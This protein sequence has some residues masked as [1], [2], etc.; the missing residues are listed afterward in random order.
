M[1]IVRLAVLIMFLSSACVYADDGN[2]LASSQCDSSEI[3]IQKVINKHENRE[4]IRLNGANI[5]HSM[6]NE[7]E[8][9]YE[10]SSSIGLQGCLNGTL[11]RETHFFTYIFDDGTDKTPKIMAM[12]ITLSKNRPLKLSLNAD[13]DGIGG[14]ETH[15]VYE[16]VGFGKIIDI[17]DDPEW[18]REQTTIRFAPVSA[19]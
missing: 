7:L 18:F 4:E 5:T 2:A 1:A 16:A 13:W 14:Q 19:D 11:D 10:Y 6:K 17:S 12:S 9:I 8:K 15:S 3:S